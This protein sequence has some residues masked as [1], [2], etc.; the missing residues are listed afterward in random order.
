MVRLA[1]VER[2]VPPHGLPD[3]CRYAS[4]APSVHYSAAPTADAEHRTGALLRPGEEGCFE[5]TV[6]IILDMLRG[7]R[8]TEPHMWS[9]V[10]F[11]VP[12]DGRM[13]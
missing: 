3:S 10:V 1:H 5:V 8:W 6:D 7:M 12:Y 2:T 4:S 9:T 11:F 13:P